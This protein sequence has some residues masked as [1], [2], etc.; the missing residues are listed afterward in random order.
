MMQQLRDIFHDKDIWWGPLTVLMT[1]ALVGFGVYALATGKSLDGASLIIGGL[2]SNQ[3]A[4]LNF[5]YGSSK[6]SKDKDK[7]KRTTTEL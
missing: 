5:R 4:L 1:V 7:E 6:G 3:S 2:L